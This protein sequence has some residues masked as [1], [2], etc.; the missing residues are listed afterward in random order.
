MITL[1]GKVCVVTGALG[2]IGRELA[3]ALAEAGG[4]VVITDLD[5]GACI[6]RAHALG[7]EAMGHG[8]DITRRDSLV[9]LL[10]AI[11]D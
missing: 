1:G 8:A 4:R 2:L 9:S 6:D 11:L 7:G 3:H 5:H 10:A